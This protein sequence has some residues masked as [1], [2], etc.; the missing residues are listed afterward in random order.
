MPKKFANFFTLFSAPLPYTR[1]TLQNFAEIGFISQKLWLFEIFDWP[2]FCICP[3]LDA[4]Y[5]LKL[6]PYQNRNTNFLHGKRV[7]RENLTYLSKLRSPPASTFY[8][9][10][11]LIPPKLMSRVPGRTGSSKCSPRINETKYFAQSSESVS[12]FLLFANYAGGDVQV[13]YN[14][15]MWKP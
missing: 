3:I 10:L 8:E 5:H 12:L 11:L 6:M 1:I 14:Q 2:I 7:A 13:Q 15:I 9:I 4:F